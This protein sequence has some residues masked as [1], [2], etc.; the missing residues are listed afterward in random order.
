MVT[1]RFIYDELAGCPRCHCAMAA[2]LPDGSLLATWYAGTH[3]G[4]ADS[5]VFVSRFRPGADAWDAPRCVADTPDLSDGNSIVFVSRGA[6]VSPAVHLYFA[7][8]TGPG[9]DSAH[10]SQMVSD[11]LG[12][13]FSPRQD[14][15][16]PAGFLVRNKAIVL[17]NNRVLW[18][19]YDETEWTSLCLISDDDGETWRQSGRIERTNGIGNIQPTLVERANGDIIALLRTGGQ[20][21]FVWRSDSSD[22]GETWSPC[23]LT[24]RP[25]PNSGIDAVRLTDGRVLLVYNHTADGRTPLNLA[26]SCDECATW[27]PYLTLESAPGEYSYP[28][29][30]QTRDGAVHVL[31]TWRR[32]KIKHA[33]LLVK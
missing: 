10:M 28:A 31:Y 27:E 14:M 25:N 8:I 2:E 17:A 1:E 9:W 24:D 6:G 13:T 32:E 23:V 3:E 26:L 16:L 22:G 29:I 21:G 18:P 5:A 12:E 19:I 11:D 30:L 20:G 15:G 4:H 33:V 7:T